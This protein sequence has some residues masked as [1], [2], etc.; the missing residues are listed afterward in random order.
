MSCIIRTN[1]CIQKLTIL[2]LEW[3]IT[4]SLLFFLLKCFLS[5]CCF[6]L[7]SCLKARPHMSH[8]NGI[9]PVC[10][11][12]W[13]VRNSFCINARPH[14]S[15]LY[16]RSFKCI[17]RC[18]FN[19]NKKWFW[20]YIYWPRFNM[21]MFRIRTKSSYLIPMLDFKLFLAKAALKFSHL[22]FVRI[23]MPFQMVMTR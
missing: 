1:K 17:L 15:H 10:V 21:F 5:V 2:Y 9:S 6:K 23:K 8:L 4:C 18:I 14:S 19:R 11:N 7:T 13:R 16:L 20:E 12:L 22:I 3:P